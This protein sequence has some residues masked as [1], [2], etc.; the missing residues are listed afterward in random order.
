VSPA[1]GNSKLRDRVGPFWQ[2]VF[3]HPGGVLGWVLFG[4]T[5]VGGA[6]MIAFGKLETKARV[7]RDRARDQETI[8][9]QHQT[10]DRLG[11]VIEKKD[12][13]IERFGN[14]LDL[15]VHM[16]KELKAAATSAQHRR[17]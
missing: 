15:V 1:A 11:V 3:Q 4:C 5:I 8:E 2:W 10:I 13:V 12:A 6:L 7:D 17:R 9:R 16:V 14:A